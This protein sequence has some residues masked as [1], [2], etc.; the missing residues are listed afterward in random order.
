MLVINKVLVVCNVYVY[1]IIIELLYND[2]IL[3]NG[4]NC[5]VFF[6]DK[7]ENKS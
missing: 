4:V 6:I 3:Y 2:I 1:K 7:N 5:F